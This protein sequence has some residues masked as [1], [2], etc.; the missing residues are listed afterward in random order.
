M[1]TNNPVESYEDYLWNTSASRNEKIK[2]E[3]LH[4]KIKSWGRELLEEEHECVVCGSTKNLVPH[5]IAK[6]DRYNPYYVDTDNGV[7]MCDTCHKKYHREYSEINAKTLINF[8][9]QELTK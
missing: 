3:Q 7:V 6:I 1:M 2:S 4:W 5:H 9:K 8:I